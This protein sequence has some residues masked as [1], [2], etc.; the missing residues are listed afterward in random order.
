MSD[1]HRATDPND[2]WL[3][4][5]LL[6]QGQEIDRLK[7]RIA[8]LEGNAYAPRGGDFWPKAPSKIWRPYG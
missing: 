6:S 2:A 4:A 7:R 3:R 8:E 5:I 1:A